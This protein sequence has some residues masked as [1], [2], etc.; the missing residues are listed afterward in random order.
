M[1]NYLHIFKIF[2]V[3]VVINVFRSELRGMYDIEGIFG[4]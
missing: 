3:E 4:V 1:I 2:S